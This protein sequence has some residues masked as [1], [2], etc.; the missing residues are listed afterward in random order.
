MLTSKKIIF[1]QYVTIPI[2]MVHRIRLNSSFADGT[3]LS[4][5]SIFK[6][7]KDIRNLT[8]DKELPALSGKDASLWDGTTY[9]LALNFHDSRDLLSFAL[10]GLYIADSTAVRLKIASDGVLKGNVRSGRLAFGNNYVKRLSLDLDNSGNGLVGTFTMSPASSSTKTA[11]PS[12]Q[13]TTG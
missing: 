13:R 5:K 3:Y 12:S 11:V 10:P 2:K 6:M 7:A 9:D 8:L 1:V 4:S